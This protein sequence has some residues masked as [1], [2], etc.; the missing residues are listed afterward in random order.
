MAQ[1]RAAA[2][3]QRRAAAN[4]VVLAAG[5]MLVVLAGVRPLG[6]GVA[7]DLERAGLGPLGGE[8]RAPFG[9]G[10]LD[11]VTH[12]EQLIS[13]PPAQSGGK[14]A[15]DSNPGCSSNGDS[16]RR[17]RVSTPEKCLSFA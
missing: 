6:G 7:G 11:F 9:V 4:A 17:S 1:V 3:A 13:M 10:F 14:S 12:D 2:R 5:P 16:S 8:Q 15:Y